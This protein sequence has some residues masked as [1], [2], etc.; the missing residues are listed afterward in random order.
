[1]SVTDSSLPAAFTALEPFVRSWALEGAN[2]RLQARLASS[3]A[4]RLSFFEAAKDLL[5][6]GLEYLD[7]KP[8]A[9][10][11]DQDKRLMS[12]LLSMAHVALAVETQ[13]SDEAQ[14]AVGARHMTIT[15]APSDVKPVP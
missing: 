9:E 10:F 7:K 6:P 5:A 2:N 11:S 15:R 12:L 13:G 4:D 3:E 14:H 1:M 8:F